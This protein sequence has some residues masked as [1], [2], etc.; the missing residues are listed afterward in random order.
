[1]HEANFRQTKQLKSGF[2]PQNA[3][4]QHSILMA[5]MIPQAF[6][7]PQIYTDDLSIM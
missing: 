3:G 6:K 5:L 7:L 1:M 2:P 4:H